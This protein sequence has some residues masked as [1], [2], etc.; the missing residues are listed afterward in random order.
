[1]PI[2]VISVQEGKQL[3]QRGNVSTILLVKYMVGSH[4]P[5]TLQTSQTDINNGTAN[6]QMQAFANT[7]ASL[8]GA[9]Q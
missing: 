5:F 6:Q 8:P 4:G 2:K 7:L 9:G 1:M 3:D